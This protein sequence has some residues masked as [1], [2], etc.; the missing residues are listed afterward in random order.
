MTIERRDDEMQTKDR[1]GASP[2]AITIFTGEGTA[3][4]GH[5][6]D[7]RR[8]RLEAE[9]GRERLAAGREGVRQR[10]GHALMALGRAIHGIEANHAARPALDTSR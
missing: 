5:E 1:F 6:I 10:L 4:M 8:Q 7:F 3:T 2:T 9:A